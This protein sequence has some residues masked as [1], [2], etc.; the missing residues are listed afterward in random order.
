MKFKLIKAYCCLFA[1]VLITACSIQQ[2]TSKKQDPGFAKGADVSWLPQMEATGFK[3]YNEKGVAEDCF[4]ILKE[5]GI[6][7]IRLHT[8]VHPS[9][10]KTSGHC[11]K[12]ETVAVAVR[13]KKWGMRVLK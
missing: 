1:L 5:H 4:K 8:F 2:S 13:A 6:N 3:F 9:N 10:D 11:S 12:D 7:A